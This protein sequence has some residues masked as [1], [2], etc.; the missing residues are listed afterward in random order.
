MDLPLIF[1]TGILTSFH[2]VSMCGGLVL[3]YTVSKEQKDLPKKME[4]RTIPS[5]IGTVTGINF[6]PHFVYNSAKILSYT[7]VGA[8][9]GALGSF[10]NF[11]GIR[12]YVAIAAGIFMLVLALNLLGVGWFKKLTFRMPKF[13]G[14]LTY[15]LSSNP[16]SSPLTLGFLTGF[17]PCGPLQAMQLYAAGTGSAARGAI[18]MLVFGLGTVP[19]MFSFGSFA[20]LLKHSFREKILKLAAGVVLILGFL[21]LNRGLMV[22]GFKYN[23]YNATNYFIA[24]E[25]GESHIDPV[26]GMTVTSDKYIATVDGV[27]YYFCVKECRDFYISQSKSQG[28]KVEE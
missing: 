14:N 22:V 23:T 25:S 27:K 9:F 8:L 3:S 16:H 7:A 15:K 24:S 26:C 10:L 12:G 6:L 21:I 13:L 20:S 19:L 5:P 18:V 11:G 2:C 17:M 28:K 1:L 4:P